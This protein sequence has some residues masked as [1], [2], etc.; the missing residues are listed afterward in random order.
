MENTKEQ[1]ASANKAILAALVQNYR[2]KRTSNSKLPTIDCVYP[3]YTSDGNTEAFRFSSDLRGELKERES[4]VKES[5]AGKN[6]I[7]TTNREILLGAGK[8]APRLGLED[9]ITGKINS[10]YSYAPI[11]FV[12]LDSEQFTSYVVKPV[13]DC[14][15]AWFELTSKE[16]LEVKDYLETKAREKPY[17]NLIQRIIGGKNDNL[18]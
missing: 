12:G 17:R 3:S 13:I 11:L 16:T 2:F 5:L 6:I 8:L 14:S 15:M 10:I 9:Q 1:N 7:W 4:L 18:K